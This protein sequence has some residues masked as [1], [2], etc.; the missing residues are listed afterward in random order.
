MSCGDHVVVLGAGSIGCWVGG[1]LSLAGGGVRVSFLM[2]DSATGRALRAAVQSVGLTLEIAGRARVLPPAACA[3]AFASAGEAPERLR[4]ATYVLVATKRHANAAVAELLAAHLPARVPIVLLQNG[5]GAADEMRALLGGAAA[6]DR[7]IH[8]AVV[9]ISAT[10]AHAEGRVVR[11]GPLVELVLDGVAPLAALLG[12]AGVPTRIVPSERH[13]CELRGK[14]ML[15]MLNAPNA[16]FKKALGPM[17]LDRDACALAA[18]TMA[19]LRAV[20]AT[21][22]LRVEPRRMRALPF[23]MRALAWWPLN[24]L[25]R[26]LLATLAL[27]SG[28]DPLAGSAAKSSTVED[29]DAGRPTEIA[30]LN[31]AVVQLGERVGVPTPANAAAVRAVC[32]LEAEA[33]ARHAFANSAKREGPGE[34]R[35]E[36]RAAEPLADADASDGSRTACSQEQS[37]TPVDG[38]TT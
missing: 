30:F 18:E 10:L 16:I 5:L 13:A 21:L 27:L 3:S 34:G 1:E 28:R 6:A 32:A 2:R 12:R 24:A 17:L 38:D 9:T 7:P 37:R 26:T 19:E 4:G 36:A 33:I 23:V 31:G 22:G 20:F 14:L 35:G 29:L 11:A 25:L 15:N 8:Q